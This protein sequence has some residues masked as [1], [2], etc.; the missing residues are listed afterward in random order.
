MDRFDQILPFGGAQLTPQITVENIEDL[1]GATANLHAWHDFD[2]A[3]VS[4]SGGLISLANRVGGGG[5]LTEVSGFANL[6]LST[7]DLPPGGMMRQV[8]MFNADTVLGATDAFMVDPTPWTQM[9]IYCTSLLHADPDIGTGGDLTRCAQ[10]VINIHRILFAN[11]QVSARVG[12]T[13]NFL[14]ADVRQAIHDW[15]WVIASWVPSTKTMTNS[16]N[17]GTPVVAVGT[18]QT[19]AQSTFY[20]GG[21]E[22]NPTYRG[23]MGHVLSW[24]ADLFDASRADDLALLNV[25]GALCCGKY[26]LIAGLAA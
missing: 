3:R 21:S 18:T 5:A 24:S 2:P 9:V 22:T 16:I 4:S 14:N 6:T 15:G 23:A 12:I 26:D 10:S 17:N 1:V 13:A 25:F 7:D 20:I 8:G 19:N 11:S